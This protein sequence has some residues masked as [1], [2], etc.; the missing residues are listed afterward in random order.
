MF[1]SFKNVRFFVLL[2]LLQTACKDPESPPPAEFSLLNVR[3]GTVPLSETTIREDLPVS[4]EFSASFSSAIDTTSVRTGI[5]ITA[6]SASTPVPV[7]FVFQDENREVQLLPKDSLAWNTMFRLDFTASLKGS[8]GQTF[9]PKAFRFKTENGRLILLSAT[10][11]GR[12][13]PS[14]S[15]L[16][17]IPFDT[18]RIQLQ[19]SHALDASTFRNFVFIGPSVSPDLEYSTDRRS[20]TIRSTAPL[21][22]YRRHTF[23]IS[24]NLTAANGF[25]F[26]GY[27][28]A[29]VTGLNPSIKKPLLSDEALITLV[30]QQTFKYFWDFAHPVSGL[31]RERN[32]SGELVTIGGSGFGVMGILVGIER[33]FITRQQGVERLNKIV[34][35]LGNADRFHGVW[36]HWMNGSTGRTIPFSTNDN[37]GDLVETA[38]MAQGLITARQYLNPAMPDEAAIITKINT[39]LDTI[40]WSW[41]SRG[42]QNVLFWHWS[43]DK[44]W[45]MN[46]QISGYNEAL[47]VY[48]LAATSKNFGIDPSVY[49][50]G[51]ARS[52]AIRNNKTFYGIQLP[53]GYDFGGPLFFAHYS[54]LGLDPRNLSD[55]YANYWTQNV[56]HTRINREHCVRN[57]NGNVGYGTFCWG[58]TASDN[59]SGYGVHEPTRDPGTITPTAALSSYPYTPEYSLEA[60]KHFYYVLGDKLWGEYGFYDAFNANEGWFAPSFLAIDQGP[61][62]VMIENHRSSL[63]WN[64]FM[65]APE[66]QPALSKLG[67][68]TTST[69]K[70]PR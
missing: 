41:Y 54:F 18:M 50:Q 19:F 38:F 12:P 47:I 14:S 37:G 40:E 16:R 29:F 44:N 4:S 58:L 65:S 39:L 33:G 35:F 17:N 2:L 66:V 7:R 70:Q 8:R 61:I 46:M 55:T 15:P 57:P 24:S 25:S 1:S 64:L 63:L 49:T 27:S 56:N 11:N 9:T 67:F 62:L 45:A 48:I 42:G 28:R 43:P 68:S 3:G 23:T 51:W 21:D 60:L 30:Q 59:P 6:E 53:V 26:P 52:G 22:Y 32:N 5:T 34:T 69:S 10:I 20:V 31:A 36:P 13:F